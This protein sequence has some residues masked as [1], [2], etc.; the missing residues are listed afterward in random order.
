MST[1]TLPVYDAELKEVFKTLPPVQQL[2]L[3]VLRKEREEAAKSETHEK[4]F[5]DPEISHR[6]MEID[7]PG[8]EI[9]VTVVE[10]KNTSGSNRP[11]ILFLHG[12]CFIM[13]SQLAA[14]GTQ[15]ETIKQCDAVLVSVNYRLA[16]EHPDPAPVEDC[17]AGLKWMSKN[18]STLGIDPEK[19]IIIGLSAGG[20]LAAGTALIARDRGGPRVRGQMLIYPMLDDRV[21]TISSKQYMTE[22]TLT[23]EECVG[24]W[25][26]LL[27]GNRGG[28]EVSAYAAPAREKDLSRLPEAWLDVGSAEVLRD[29]G[30]AYASR[31]WEF[32]TQC[33][34]HIWRG[35]YHAFD[36]IAPHSKMTKTTMDLRLAWVKRTLAT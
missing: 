30:V 31:L 17:Y 8:G 27:S 13:C 25:D 1:N 36:L 18:A 15:F 16:P 29:E 19:I 10:S 7:G 2:T 34:L 33:E 20:G 24:S 11:G 14:I 21:D 23:G 3:E 32:G 28:N 26:W 4:V 9:T 35:A 12:G 22:G 6:D 5:T